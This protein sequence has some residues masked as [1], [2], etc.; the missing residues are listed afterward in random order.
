MLPSLD[1]LKQSRLNPTI[2]ILGGLSS[3]NIS[4]D[5]NGM[6]IPRPSSGAPRCFPPCHFG[7]P[8]LPGI[9]SSTP[10][11]VLLVLKEDRLTMEDLAKFVTHLF[12]MDPHLPPML[13]P[14][15]TP[16][17]AR[18]LREEEGCKVILVLA[19][20]DGMTTKEVLEV[21]LAIPRKINEW[22]VAHA[23][24]HLNRLVRAGLLHYTPA[25]KRSKRFRVNPDLPGLVSCCQASL[26]RIL[27]H[28]DDAEAEIHRK[29]R[30]IKD[31]LVGGQ[32]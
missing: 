15:L 19:Q 20:H 2:L 17:D 8:T 10:E 31:I 14:P 25:D 24:L 11:H 28:L 29:R 32:R 23:R 1:L 27:L 12:Q 7:R 13:P 18:W 22:E 26:E 3:L 4:G 5:F 6:R 21:L 30:S 16:A 9:V